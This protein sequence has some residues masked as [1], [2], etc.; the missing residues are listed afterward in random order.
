MFCKVN[1]WHFPVIYISTIWTIVFAFEALPQPQH[2]PKS[3]KCV[4][5]YCLPL[6]YKKLEAPIK[7]SYTTVKIE[8]DIMDVLTVSNKIGKNHKINLNILIL[9]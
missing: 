9:N 7:D 4:S 5:G 3:Q 2:D 6:D 8:T 1:N